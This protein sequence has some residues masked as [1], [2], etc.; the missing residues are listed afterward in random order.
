M[1]TTLNG[2][3]LGGGGV[4]G[5]FELGVLTKLLGDPRLGDRGFD[6][7]SGTSTGAITAAKLAEGDTL[8]T[9]QVALNE[10]IRVYM[11]IKGNDD[12]FKS[13]NVLS[14]AY[15]VLTKGAL[16]DPE[17]LL[18]LIR[19][20]ISTFAI[21]QSNTALRI[22][23][24]ELGSGDLDTFT[25]RAAK[26]EYEPDELLG[27][28]DAVLASCTMP[29][30][31]PPVRVGAT[32]AYVDGGVRAVAPLKPAIEALKDQYEWGGSA[33]PTKV[34]LF[35]VLAS[36]LAIQ[37]EPQNYNR[38]D[39]IVARSLSL[40][41]SDNTWNDLSEVLYRNAYPKHTDDLQINVEVYAPPVYYTP[42]LN[43]DPKIIRQMYAD[44]VQAQ[45]LPPEDLPT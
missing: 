18:K 17:P 42:A 14:R 19:E 3:V 11:G 15:R 16:Y 35:V 13:G 38:F 9:Q 2:V 23:A 40:S 7:V 28:H 44:G 24:V 4:K 34:N 6:V 36:P 22:Q 10:L 21:S 41:L 1:S 43:F 45:P 32:L 25:G 33:E 8:A 20:H 5:A 26:D 37:Y 30:F 29:G 12:M 27:I 39:Q 31:F